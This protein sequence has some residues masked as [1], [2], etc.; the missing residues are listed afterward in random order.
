MAS[1]EIEEIKDRLNIVD[2]ISDYVRLKKAG[3]NFKATCP[4]HHEKTPSFYVT[5]SRQI[6][7]CFGC[8]QGGDVIEFVKQIEQLTFPEALE[9]LAQRAGIQ[10]QRTFTTTPTVAPD[11]KPMLYRANELAVLFFEKVLETSKSA[12]PARKYLKKRKLIETTRKTFRLGYSPEA[13]DELIKFMGKKG[14]PPEDLVDAGLAGRA[15]S[16]KFYD[17]FRGRLMFPILDLAGKVVGFTGRLIEKKD[18]VAKYINS[19]DSPIYNKSRVLYGLYQARAAIREAGSVVIVEGNMDVAKSHQAG[20]KNVVA[21]SGTALT[22]EHLKLLSRFTERFI[23]SFDRDPAGKQAG[24]RAVRLALQQGADVSMAR[25]PDGYKDPD[26]AIDKDPKI[27]LDALKKPDNFLDFYFKEVFGIIDLRNAQ[28]KK[29]ATDKFL[30][31]LSLVRDKVVQSHY[32]KK[33]SETVGIREQVAAEL[34]AEKF[35]QART[36]TSTPSTENRRA[37]NSGVG[38]DRNEQ[39]CLGLLAVYPELHAAS[40]QVLRTEFFTQDL[41]RQ[42]F[43]YLSDT[44][45]DSAGKDGLKTKLDEYTFLAEEEFADSTIARQVFQD[46]LLKLGRRYYDSLQQ[47]I[48]AQITSAES[49][50]ETADRKKQ[51]GRYEKILLE[52]DN[53]FNLISKLNFN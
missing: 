4:F 30:D 53:F 8:G 47:E 15:E 44:N 49:E 23:F 36:Y 31:L 35:S 41:H 40:R 9:K 11:K 2:V 25:L 39:R 22:A 17:R 12:E 27:W 24:E 42:L 10:L 38:P 51:L 13:W 26:E 20:V 52:K 45:T 7:H 6:W 48:T 32:L 46:V 1:T 29:T 3:A 16:G 18:D 28:E 14:F 21:A 34:L 33:V 19:S 50:G 37:S 5:P 43:E